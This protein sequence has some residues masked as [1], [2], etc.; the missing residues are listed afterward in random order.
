MA[1]DYC[2]T[3]YKWP[4]SEVRDYTLAWTGAEEVDYSGFTI[5]FKADSIRI[6]QIGGDRLRKISFESYQDF[7]EDFPSDNDNVFSD[8]GRIL[9]INPNCG[10]S[11][12]I[13]AFG[14]Y[15]A[16]VDPTDKAATTAFSTYDRE[17]NEAIVEKMTSFLKRREHLAEE[18]ELHDQRTDSVLQKVFGKVQK[19]QFKY[20]QQRGDEGIF[21][22]FDVVEGGFRDE[23]FN[24]DQFI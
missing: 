8:F 3:Q 18:A 6:L 13:A 24:R 12:T 1:N 14:Q 9:F 23:V 10:L 16:L 20:Q 21:K 22:R 2:V 5:D 19:E 17:G 11:G 4:F 15:T 7:R